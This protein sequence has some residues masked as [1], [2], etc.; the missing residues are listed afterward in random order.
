MQPSYNIYFAGQL[1]PGHDATT[2]RAGLGKLFNADDQ[3]LDKLFSGKAQLIKRGCDKATALKYKQAMEA[4]GA[5]PLIRAEET[6]PAATNREQPSVSAGSDTRTKPLTAAER[7]A[8]LA[9]APDNSPFNPDLP[10][11]AKDAASAEQPAEEPPPYGLHLAPAGASVLRADERSEPVVS[12]T[13]TSELSV[14]EHA[15]R[16]SPEPPPPPPAPD[17]S[18]LSMGGVGETIPTLPRHQNTLSPNTQGIDLSPPG[19]DF[20][21][22]NPA[23]APAPVLDLSAMVLAETGADVLEER[24]RQHRQPAAPD[25]DHLSISEPD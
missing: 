24:Y 9:A 8:A 22:C 2:V 3:T 12:V 1:L 25:T 11:A 20:A 14:A 13:D 4:A 16:L 23:P 5:Q 6:V 15:Q 19:T 17:T 10:P 7:I 21:D 18:S